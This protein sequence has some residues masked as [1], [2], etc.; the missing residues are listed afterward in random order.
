VHYVPTDKINASTRIRI[1]QI[2]KVQIS[3]RRLQILT[4]F[5]ISLAML[6]LLMDGPTD[7]QLHTCTIMCE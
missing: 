3:V 1:L 5:I 7:A 6:P 4:S 2:L